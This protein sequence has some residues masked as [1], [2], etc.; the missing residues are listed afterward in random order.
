MKKPQEPSSTHRNR[1]SFPFEGGRSSDCTRNWVSRPSH[2]FGDHIWNHY[3]KIGERQLG[4]S[5]TGGTCTSTKSLCWNPLP[6]TT[7]TIRTPMSSR[8][9]L[10]TGT[11]SPTQQGARAT[12]YNCVHLVHLVRYTLYHKEQ[13]GRA[14]ANIDAKCKT[15][16]YARLWFL[17]TKNSSIIPTLMRKWNLT[18]PILNIP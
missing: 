3:C 2:D 13:G 6:R 10:V 11:N 12:I 7:N 8:E 4:G 1:R 18:G 15:L 17:C 16:L 5:L 9:N 14:L